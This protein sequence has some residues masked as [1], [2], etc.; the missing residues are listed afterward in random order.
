M[1]K[2][3]NWLAA[4][5]TLFLLLF[6]PS[7]QLLAAEI[8]LQPKL[9]KTTE[10]LIVKLRDPAAA[11]QVH[12]LSSDRLHGLSVKAGVTLSYQRAMAGNLQ[13]L[14]LPRRMNLAEAQTVT[15]R[16]QA[17][18]GVVY[19]EPDQIKFP[20]LVPNDTGYSNQWHYKAPTDETGGTNL[21]G[22]WDITT[23]S[24]GLTVAVI[25]SGILPHA[26]LAGRTTSGYD[27][28]SED[29][30]GVFLSANDGNGRDPDPTDPGDWISS[31][32]SLGTAAG[33]FFSGCSVSDSDWH[34]THVA[35]TIAA[36]TNNG[37]GVAGVNWGSKVLPVRVLGKCGGYD[38]DI[39]DAMRWAAGLSV[40]GVPSNPNPARVLNMSLGGGSSGCSA[41]YQD[42]INQVNAAGAVVVA[43]AG[44][45]NTVSNSSPDS[46]NGVIN[47]AATNRFGGKASYSNFGD[48]VALS[49]PG[50][51][52]FSNF[53]PNGIL[54]TYNT[55]TT[56]PAADTYAY[57][58]GTSFAAPHVAGIASLMLSAN[59]NL[60]PAQVRSILQSTARIF[61]PGSTCN[62]NLCG[63]GIVNAAAAVAQARDLA[64]PGPQT[65]WW[66]N[67]AQS[68]RGF[69]IE[70]SGNNM[71]MAGYLYADDGRATWLVSTGP[72]TS[73][74]LYSGKLLSFGGG[75]TLSGTFK[76]NT[77]TNGD[78][79][80]ITLQFIDATHGTLTWP[81]GAIP[82]ERFIFSSGTPTFQPET[83]WWWNEAESGR[84]FAIEIQGNTL[85]MAG[86][87][88]DDSGNP[89]WYVT[90]GAMATPTLYQNAWLQFAN[91]QTLT[92]PFKQNQ[93]INGNAGGITL[94]FNS[95]TTATLT[96]PGGRRI[97]LTRFR[98]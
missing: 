82:I 59:P 31:E 78:V 61:P 38:S 73:S 70:V 91:G 55:G 30:P 3:N 27:F 68:G 23:G 95:S 79:G 6:T 5:L 19:A 35:G 60:N 57:L 40:P 4:G 64:S 46:C 12:G 69:T 90:E 20:R 17:D 18:P 84:G 7:P 33:G 37:A 85:F 87:M 75:Q 89:V 50:G 32:E 67:P 41:A 51:E 43:A 36:A 45:G 28:V 39:L 11:G 42:A 96:L 66:W 54:S 15:R 58:Q 48:K 93:L 21:P 74:N 53:D 63:A 65:G 80:N 98:F 2:L 13:L 9:A 71:F 26:D 72:M 25:D 44:N 1:N 47:V 16:L 22:A 8:S 34:G 10:R 49:A 29:A 76:S 52:A 77:L 94:Q 88:Y 24:P 97:P 86:Y 83:G 56:T 14:K 62:T 81:G 92:G